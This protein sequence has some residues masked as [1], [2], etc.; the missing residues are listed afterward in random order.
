MKNLNLNYWINKQKKKFDN[1][2]KLISEITKVETK[3]NLQL[4]FT[5]SNID[6]YCD[7]RNL[8]VYIKASYIQNKQPN[9]S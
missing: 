9:K 4:F 8:L 7:Y 3:S 2:D 1:W 6:Q 5:I